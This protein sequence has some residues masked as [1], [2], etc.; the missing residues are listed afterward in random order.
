[1]PEQAKAA[2]AGWG[3]A[4]AQEAYL[5]EVVALKAASMVVETGG[6]SAARRAAEESAAAVKAAWLVEAV[7]AV[8]STATGMMAAVLQAVAHAVAEVAASREDGVMAGA[9]GAG[10]A[11][12]R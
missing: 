7:V 2:A 5:G 6:G 3:G 11:A 12:V 4:R 1:M 10:R 8:A 9:R